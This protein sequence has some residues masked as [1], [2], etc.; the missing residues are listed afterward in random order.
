MKL[1]R[2]KMIIL[3]VK[4]RKQIQMWNLDLDVHKDQEYQYQDSER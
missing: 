1:R 4:Q 3:M 2:K